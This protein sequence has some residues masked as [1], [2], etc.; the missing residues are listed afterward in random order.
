MRNIH[1]LWVDDEIDLLKPHILFLEKKDY[2]VTTCTNGTDAIELVSENNFDIVFLDENMPGIT[3]LETLSE[4]KQKNTNLPI[5]M[6]TKSEEEYL[7]EEAI[8][9]KIADYLI[10]PVNPNQILL[11]LK[12]NLDHSRL[13]SEKTTSSYQQEFRKISMDLAMVNSY[14]EWAELYKK[15]VHW[16]LELENIND[17]GMLEILE[18]QKSEANSQFFKFIKKNYQHWLTGDDKPTFSHTLFKDYIVPNLSKKQGVLWVVIDNLRYDQYRVLE[19]FI[20]NYFKKEEEYSYYSILPTAT[21]YA[22]NAIFSGLM[23]SEMEKRH[24]NYWKNDTDEGGKNLFEANFLDEQIKRLGL[25]ITHEYYKIVSLKSGKDLADNYNGTRQNDLTAV[26]YNF[27]DMLSHAKTEME[28]IKELAGDDKAYRSLT[29]SW[30][31]NSPLYDIIQKAQK[32]GQKLIITTD[33]GTINCKHPTKVIGD[34]NISSNLR[35]KTGRS[36]SYENKDV[37]A[38]K[39]PKDIFLPSVAINSP[40]IFTKEDLFFAYPNNYNHFVKYYKNTYQHGGISL[41]EMVIPCAVYNP[42]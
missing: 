2:T 37:Y 23:P 30:F 35:Y 26:V 19:P 9:S 38:V 41:E 20:N 8:G 36:L 28:V 40:F 27:V 1:I 31:K 42:K 24:P 6:I 5:V 7:M 11:S 17:T 39:N 15:L 4:I 10:K 22:R 33:H 32:L 13:I 34:K 25:N 3:G 21:Q 12:K 14:E 29:V 16:E 18:S